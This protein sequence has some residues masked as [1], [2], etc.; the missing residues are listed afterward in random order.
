[1][2][3]ELAVPS[4]SMDNLTP[5]LWKRFRTP[6]SSQN[7]REFLEKMRLITRD[8]SGEGGD[9]GE[10]RPSGSYQ[11]DA[12]DITGPL[13]VQIA[14][15]CRFVERNMRVFAVKAPCRIET[16][17]FSMN[18][19]AHRDYA[20]Y[21]SKIRLHLFSDRLKIHSPGCLPNSMTVE[22]IAER[23]SSRNEL[24]TSLLARTP[25][26][27]NAP[28]SRRGFI[29][30][31]R[32]DGVPGY[33]HRKRG[34]LGPTARVPAARRC[35]TAPRHLRGAGAGAGARGAARLWGVPNDAV[36]KSYLTLHRTKGYCRAVKSADF[37]WDEEK[38]RSNINK[39][40]GSTMRKSY[41]FSKGVRNPYL[42]ELKRPI[43]VEVNA[44]TIDYFKRIAGE[45]GLDYQL[46]INLYLEDCA[47]NNLRPNIEWNSGLMDTG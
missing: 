42:S 47:R 24:L 46:L 35:R 11:L 7:N 19:V 33:H 36:M 21:A 2:A 41:D 44:D 23:Q 18:A 28:G 20:I 8:I 1:M 34:T 43:A 26:N 38:N 25:M 9:A 40:S 32:G 16:P 6:L 31:R 39:G 27:V 12:K 15:A 30:D 37:E 29:M 14:G 22:S 10:F 4:S 5:R 3:D 17:Q 13:D 45:T